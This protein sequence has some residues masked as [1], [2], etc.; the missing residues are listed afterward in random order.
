MFPVDTMDRKPVIVRGS[1]KS[2]T[3]MTVPAI[4]ISMGMAGRELN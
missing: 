2:G 1:G 4:L 3:A